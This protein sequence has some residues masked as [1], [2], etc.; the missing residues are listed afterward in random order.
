MF[1]RV[2]TAALLLAGSFA[3]TAGEFGRVKFDN[4][5]A[6]V[7]QSDFHDALALLHDFEYR[8]AAEAFQRAQVADPGFAM[9]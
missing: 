1:A 2:L 5:G 6:P 8:A 7:A 3:V 4:S 9:A